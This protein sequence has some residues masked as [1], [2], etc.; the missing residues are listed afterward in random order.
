MVSVETEM[1][2]VKVCNS[3]TNTGVPRFTCTGDQHES[4]SQSGPQGAVRA[5]AE[6]SG[7]LIKDFKISRKQIYKIIKSHKRYLSEPGS[8]GVLS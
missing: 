1:F 4:S 2:A 8:F 3:P 6:A 5:G 7:V